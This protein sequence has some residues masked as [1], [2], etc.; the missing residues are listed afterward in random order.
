MLVLGFFGARMMP[1]SF[2][3][4]WRAAGVIDPA[5]S[6]VRYVEPTGAGK[7]QIVVDET[8]QRTLSGSV[9]DRDI[10]RLL[11]AAAKDPADAGLRVESVDLLK[12]RPQSGGDAERA[13]VCGAARSQRRRAVEGAGWIEGFC[14][15]SGHAQSADAGSVD[16]RQP[17]GAHAGDRSA[18]PHHSDAMVGVL[19]EL[20]MKED[21]DYIRMRCR[22]CCTR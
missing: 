19:Q 7:I 10:Q 13:A 18:D 11:L 3:G 9:D 6:R 2:L 21:N 4:A 22:K 8:R 5:T 16:G 15:R 17:R 14:G 20:M 1:D 12:N